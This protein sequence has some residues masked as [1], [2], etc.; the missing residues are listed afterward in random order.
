MHLEAQ[1]FLMYFKIHFV[2]NKDGVWSGI[3]GDLVRG[4]IDISVGKILI[5]PGKFLNST[6][7][8][9]YLNSI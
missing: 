5:V 7:F 6:L 1:I 3:M 8:N 9:H 4:D 2:R